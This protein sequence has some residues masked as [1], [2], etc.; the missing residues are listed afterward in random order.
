ML[1]DSQ[2]GEGRERQVFP[3]I[4]GSP[5][6]FV[7]ATAQFGNYP[8]L[9]VMMLT[10]VVLLLVCLTGIKGQEETTTTTTT[11]TTEAPSK[12]YSILKDLDFIIVLHFRMFETIEW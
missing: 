6:S 5:S 10:R 2:I 3:R 11:T 8:S 1:S 7:T 9:T 12:S 4:W